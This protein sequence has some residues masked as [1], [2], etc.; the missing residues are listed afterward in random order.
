M[1]PCPACG[2]EKAF[3]VGDICGDCHAQGRDLAGQD[4]PKEET[5]S[6]AGEKH[7]CPK[8]HKMVANPTEHKKWCT[9]AAAEGPAAGGEQKKGKES[10]QPRLKCRY[11]GQECSKGYL[12]NH[13]HKSCPKRP[14]ASEQIGQSK[15]PKMQRK[16][17]VAGKKPARSSI[18]ADKPSPEWAAFCAECPFRGLESALAKDL[19]VRMIRGGMCMGGAAEIVRDVVRAAK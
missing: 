13:E 16:K 7:E 14:S 12:W 9:G 3:F 8:C 11:C 17:R 6:K 5:M 18:A 19:V 1:K 10:A 4:R 2:N 15:Q